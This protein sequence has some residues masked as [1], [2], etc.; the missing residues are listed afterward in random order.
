MFAIL[1]TEPEFIA[2]DKPAGVLVHP[3]AGGVLEGTIAGEALSAYPE[4]ANVGDAPKERPGI[5][6]RLDRDTSGVLVICRTQ[7]FFEYLKGQF[8]EHKVKKTYMALVHGRPAQKGKID[9]PIGLR[10]GTTK[11]SASAKKMKMVKPALTEYETLSSYAQGDEMYSLVRLVPKTGRTHQL[12]VHLAAI[13][14][15]VVGDPLYGREKNQWNLKRQFLHAASLEFMMPDG[16][17]M[18]IESELPKEL[19]E[20]LNHL[21]AL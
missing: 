10:S 19:K 4:I 11:R 12:R 6:H 13:G 18:R 15:P 3:V 7:P 1:K 5:V 17:P 16:R 21:K 20:I 14:C 2:V 8:Q 9:K